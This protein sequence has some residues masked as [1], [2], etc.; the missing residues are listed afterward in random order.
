MV[1]QYAF[2]RPNRSS[3]EYKIPF[4]T[5]TPLF[6]LLLLS[7]GCGT[8]KAVTKQQAVAP[9]I[10]LSH[11][12]VTIP[13]PNAKGSP[14]EVSPPEI[15]DYANIDVLKEFMYPDSTDRS[16]VFYTYPGSST[17]NSKYSRSELR[18]QMIPGNNDV[19]WEFADGGYMKVT[20]SVPDVTKEDSGKGHRVIIAQ[21]HGKLTK[22]QQ[23]LI[24]QKDTNAPPVP[25]IYYQYGKVEV[26]T[27][28]FPIRKPTEEEILTTKNWVD[29]EKYIFIQDVGTGKFT[30]EVFVSDGRLEV[31]LNGFEE[32]VYKNKSIQVWSVFDNYFKTRN[33]LTTRDKGAFAKK[34]YAL[35]VSYPD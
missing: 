31:K 9:N 7:L 28:V 22:A 16:I 4:C 25:K 14:T 6:F 27:K 29:D 13:T 26:R 1:D 5:L 17:D 30:L 18:E 15:M 34:I 33:Y 19:N 3:H 24:G 21:I 2:L 35:E 10:G 11:R 20:M 12:K 8:T 32:A 23:A